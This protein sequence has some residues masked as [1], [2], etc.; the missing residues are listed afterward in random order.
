MAV[1]HR[2]HDQPER[3][4]ELQN[5]AGNLVVRRANILGKPRVF[6]L[7]LGSASTPTGRIVQRPWRTVSSIHM[8]A[9][10]PAKS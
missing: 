4:A 10:I 8:R 7:N 2:V 3:T 1:H 6:L 9:M 5:G